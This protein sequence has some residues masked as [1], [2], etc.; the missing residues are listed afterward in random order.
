MLPPFNRLFPLRRPAPAAADPAIEPPL[1][2]RGLARGLFVCAS[3]SL[4]LLG[5]SEYSHHEATKGSTEVT[6]RLEIQRTL[7]AIGA[8]L[9]DAESSQR[10]FVLTG[11][12]RYLA[13]YRNAIDAVGRSARLAH[14]HYLSDAEGQA[15]YG[16][17]EQAVQAKMAELDVSMRLRQRG[18][19][20][21]ATEVVR[22]DVGLEKMEAVRDGVGR[23]LAYEEQR[24]Q[25]IT[26]DWER[27]ANWARLGIAFATLFVLM[28]FGLFLRHSERLA[29]E[30]ERQRRAVQRE[31]DELDVRIAERTAELIRLASHLQSARE[32]ERARLSRELHDELGAIFTAAKF[33][34]AAATG[35]LKGADEK[36]LARLRS[37]KEL[38]EHGVALKRRIIEDL[39]PSTLTTL[40]F[41]PAL[42]G[43]AEQQR[44]RL[45]GEMALDIEPGVTVDESSGL[46]LYR[47]AQEAFTNIY[48]YAN[49]SHVRLALRQLDAEVQLVVEDDGVGFDTALLADTPGHGLAGMK[50][51]LMSLGGRLK[52]E[53]APRRGTRVTAILP[54]R[55]NPE[56]ARPPSGAGAVGLR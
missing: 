55:T 23:L 51:R 30:S 36:A 3:L 34:L 56:T 20:E 25:V 18:Q 11:D 40:G 13:P 32:D 6:E 46:A 50:Y 17:V 47:V 53:S 12:E 42:S 45:G 27:T 31:R 14:Q 33:D 41:V 52:V 29:H 24:L 19:G 35:R 44:Q 9:V 48:K 21:A 26:R 28:T 39:R 49:A 7:Q 5:L 2:G 4:G 10:G 15:L 43:F 37:L 1:R 38:L 16:P 54:A 8:A 22:T